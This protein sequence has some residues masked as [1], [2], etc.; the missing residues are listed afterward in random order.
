MQVHSWVFFPFSDYEKATVIPFDA[1]GLN[2]YT[3][4]IYTI[5]LVHGNPNTIEDQMNVRMLEMMGID[6]AE[7]KVALRYERSTESMVQSI[8]RTPIRQFEDQEEPTV[9]IV[10]TLEDSKE[11]ERALK[12]KC[13]IDESIMMEAPSTP[14]KASKEQLKKK[15]KEMA[16]SG[17]T[18]KT[19]AKELDASTKTIQRWLKAS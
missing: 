3:D 8:C 6:V 9:H 14:K 17:D 15:A 13:I 12:K 2:T 18:H 11:I 1:R 16:D 19:I 10:P 4:H 7:G 5:N